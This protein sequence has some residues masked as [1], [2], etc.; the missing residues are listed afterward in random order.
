MKALSI[1]SI[2]VL[3]WG[4]Q[5]FAQG[6]RR[7]Q[8]R[9]P[10]PTATPS[11][12]QVAQ[13]IAENSHREPFKI[14]GHA[15][16]RGEGRNNMD[17]SDN[18]T[19]QISFTSSRFRVG[20]E[21]NPR[22]DIGIFFEPQFTKIF[23]STGATLTSGGT[24]DTGLDVHQAFMTYRP[25]GLVD[26]KLGRQELNYGDELVIGKTDWSTVGRSFDGVT[27]R[28]THSKGWVDVFVTTILET[29][30]TTSANGD[31]NFIGLYSNWNLLELIKDIDVYYLHF[32]NPNVSPHYYVTAV[33][34]RAKS[35]IDRFDF[36]L[37]TTFED[38]GATGL[39]ENQTDGEVGFSLVPERKTRAYAEYFRASKDYNQLFPSGHKYLGFAD[40]LSR[41]NLH[42][43]KLGIESLIAGDLMGSLSYHMFYRM[44]KDR[45]VY[46][47]AG[48][49]YAN[50]GTSGDVL[51][52]LDL[53][54]EYPL[55]DSLSIAG[56]LAYH[57][58]G[59]YFKDNNQKDNGYLY[60]VWARAQF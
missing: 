48:T 47:Y 38:T 10:A 11:F 57:L 15:R 2:L 27:V 29:N 32:S 26:I 45:P 9:T 6:P 17:M 28:K 43:G 35:T 46:N 51:N 60:A 22:T 59:N 21:F 53:N 50:G 52:E 34:A 39:N 25:E 36:R 19:D 40:L 14:G 24:T 31:A 41:R 5:S 58:P 23:G 33:G 13:P 7:T 3:V 16:V 12:D 49:A 20:M 4:A 1:I 30:A 55:N 56:L 18:S 54:L 8:F 42:G 37:E 44:D